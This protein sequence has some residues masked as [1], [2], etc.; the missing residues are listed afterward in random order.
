MEMTAPTLTGHRNSELCPARPFGILDHPVKMIQRK[1]KNPERNS[2]QNCAKS[3]S[4]LVFVHSVRLAIMR[5]G[6]ESYKRLWKLRNRAR[7]ISRTIRYSRPLCARAT[8]PV[9]S[10]SLRTSADMHTVSMN[11]GRKPML[12]LKKWVRKWKSN[13]WKRQKL[14]R[15]IRQS[16]AIFCVKFFTYLKIFSIL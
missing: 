16:K 6:S 10:V 5:T 15:I 1:R 14:N 13:C 3:F 11:W 12:T 2:R 7:T 4:N 9:S 8:W